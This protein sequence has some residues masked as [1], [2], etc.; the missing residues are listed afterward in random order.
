MAVVRVVERMVGRDPTEA[1]VWRDYGRVVLALDQ[2]VHEVCPLSPPPRGGPR[3]PLA[4]PP[5][6]Q[7]HPQTYMWF[8]S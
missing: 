2:A 4:P 1:S 6:P 3:C 8:L 7:T 5:T